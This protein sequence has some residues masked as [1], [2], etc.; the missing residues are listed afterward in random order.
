MGTHL[1]FQVYNIIDWA[2]DG[3]AKLKDE[4]GGCGAMTGWDWS[5]NGIRKVW[6]ALPLIIKAGCVERAIASA[7]GPQLQCGSSG[8]N[9]PLSLNPDPAIQAFS[10]AAIHPP[11]NITAIGANSN[12]T[13]MN[14]GI[15]NSGSFRVGKGPI[16]SL[17]TVPP[18]VK[19][20]IPEP[21]TFPSHLVV[22]DG[23]YSNAQ[24]SAVRYV[25]MRWP[26]HGSE[27]VTTTTTTTAAAGAT[28]ATMT[29][30]MTKTRKTSAPTN[31]RSR[32]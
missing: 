10:A 32:S 9:G 27:S 12:N 16:N 30:F 11:A 18:P 15:N 7:G 4:M 2:N 29:G 28:H 31:P 25:P 21:P 3:G 1:A 20:P 14:L 6:F 8:T 13:T 23:Q 22:P 24:S 26:K 19:T 17:P 5:D